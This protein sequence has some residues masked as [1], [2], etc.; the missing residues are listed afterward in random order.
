MNFSL[1]GRKSWLR[2]LAALAAP[3][4][5]AVLPGYAQQPIPAIQPMPP[6][7]AGASPQTLQSV[8]F[9]MG[10]RGATP[11]LTG[12]NGAQVTIPATPQGPGFS[13]QSGVQLSLNMLW[14][15]QFGY[16]PVVVTANLA[17]PA[18][19]DR[20]IKLR[21]TAGGWYTRGKSVTVE[22]SFVIPQGASSA[23]CRL[24]APQFDDWQ[25][26]SW[27][28]WVDGRQDD[29][30]EIKQLNYAGSGISGVSG[31]G[32]LGVDLDAE[33]LSVSETVLQR[34]FNAAN[35]SIRNFSLDELPDNW[36]EY[37]TLD[38]A[39]LPADKAAELVDAHPK[40]AAALLS[41]VRSGGNLWIID[42][43]R[44]WQELP[45]A[46]VKLGLTALAQPEPSPDAEE[47]AA[48]DAVLRRGWRYAPTAERATDPVEGALLLSGFETQGTRSPKPAPTS[49]GP[50]ERD[51]RRYFVVR[52]YGL[53]AIAAF[54]GGLRDGRGPR[55]NGDQALS[56]VTQ[57]LLGSRI[58]WPNRHG[59][60][61]DS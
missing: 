61:P 57:S 1:A 59:N 11:Y 56:A 19:A 36:L 49:P 40:S 23:T 25:L 54:R 26:C 22:Q 5:L 21:F 34:V 3:L 47:D 55:A 60:Q 44:Q 6:V 7:F 53:G 58:S 41:W 37:T 18:A 43:G 15:G 8:Q 45:S 4:Q 27:E 52:G 35:L 20:E 30:L 39:M 29:R 33:Q 17:K 24:L 42:S 51:S 16:R 13:A 10:P 46:E 48:D 38:I 2:R 32:V 28:T 12:V 50:L 14:P 9:A 31:M